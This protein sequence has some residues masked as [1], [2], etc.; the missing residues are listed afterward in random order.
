MTSH[1]DRVMDQDIKVSVLCNC[2]LS[3]PSFEEWQ[4]CPM[5]LTSKPLVPWWRDGG[6]YVTMT[7]IDAEPTVDIGRYFACAAIWFA[8][9]IALTLLLAEM[10]K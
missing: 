7:D 3:H 6:P 2:G 8:A 10:N 4:E 1:A 5:A 9:G